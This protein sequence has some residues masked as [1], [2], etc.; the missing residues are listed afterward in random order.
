MEVKITKTII[1]DENK[2][3]KIGDDIH[4]YLNR[5]NK[6]Y[7]CFGIITEIKEDSFEINNVQLD[8]MNVSDTLTIKY[9][10]VKDGVFHF[11]DTG[12]C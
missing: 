9:D 7:D 1:S 5:N 6:T 8:K 2:K 11:T 12:Y 4:F 3:F 10:E